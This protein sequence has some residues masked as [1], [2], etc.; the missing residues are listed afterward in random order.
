MMNTTTQ[1][2]HWRE[3]TLDVLSS[4]ITTSFFVVSIVASFLH[5]AYPKLKSSFTRSHLGPLGPQK[6]VSEGKYTSHRLKI[7]LEERLNLYK[8]L[9]YKLQ[10]LEN[11]PEVLPT[12]KEILETFLEQGLLMAR[13]KPQA[14]NILDIKEFDPVKLRKL[15]EREQDII[16][17]EFESYVRRREAGGGPE[18]FK[19][20]EEAR[21]YLKDGAPWNYTDGCWLAHIHQI[22]TPFALRGVTK[23]AWQIFSEELGDGDIEKNHVVMY[24]DLLRS[25]GVHLPDGDTADFIHPRHDMEDEQLWRFATGQ[26]LISMFP[27][28]FLPEILGFNLHYEAPGLS[29][30]KAN[31]ELP[32]FGIS[33]YYYALH[34]S[35][36]NTDSGHSAM[37]LGNIV[38]FMDIVRETGIMD[39]QSAW[40][41]VQA[42]YCLAQSSDNSETIYHYEDKLV[43][44]L[45][46]KGNVA[47]KIHCTSRARIGKRSL[48]SW[49]S[50]SS[51]ED[52]G[53]DICDDK[54]KEEFL[55]A[56]A[57]SKPW[58]YRGDSSKSRIMHELAWKGRMFGAF[59]HDEVELLRIWIDSLKKKDADPKD[60]YWDLVGGYKS[61]EKTFSPP[62]NDVAVA[63]PVFP[64]MQEWFASKVSEFIPRAPIEV[65][66]VQL[67][68]LLPLWFVHP[69]ILEN[70]ISSPHKTIAPII[71]NCLQILRAEKGYLPEGTGIAC[72]DEQL[73]PGYSPDIV[74]LGLDIVQRH[75][76]P[77][78]TCLGDVLEAPN[79][80]NNDATKFAFKLLSW[81]QRPMKNVAFLLGL[82]R[83][84]LDLEVWVASNGILLGG[85]ERRALREMIKRKTV[86]FERC[87]DQ[88]EEDKLKRCEFVG[89]YECGRTEIEKLLG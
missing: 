69:C 50:A 34:I 20:F 80:D 64:P 60:A 65:S 45:H 48:S 15:F 72:M 12:V 25:V 30:Y 53:N 52:K 5:F 73:R 22:T 35:I 79:G 14:C 84:F 27:N 13:Y 87:L 85:K 89:G 23:N 62:R 82:A 88:L 28:E 19:T 63:H 59:T 57:D 66:N 3:V 51:P 43:E 75:K 71:S 44:F 39:Y 74:A 40:K 16:K 32:E 77:V 33:P 81:A 54:W 38:Q 6:A 46:R 49:F 17:D 7:K 36:D 29:G 18:L 70:T 41:R 9:Y 67:D 26:F 83:A 76:L 10:N 2:R 8:D 56:L 37:A 86:S 4:Q 1:I 31:K 55:V 78:P 24:R 58:V 42:G 61:M 47:R 21:R 68:V 11:F